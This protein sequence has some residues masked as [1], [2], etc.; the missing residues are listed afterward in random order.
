MHLSLHFNLKCTKQ[1]NDD[2]T[3]NGVVYDGQDKDGIKEGKPAK[4]WEYDQNQF[5][6]TAKPVYYGS[7]DLQ[8]KEVPLPRFMIKP[9]D[10]DI[11]IK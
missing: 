9:T 6:A 10:C 8:C 5:I 3:L 11:I 4:Q 2:L 1:I 7:H